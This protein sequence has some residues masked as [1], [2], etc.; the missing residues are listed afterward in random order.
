M[1]KL[2]KNKNIM[3]S[4]LNILFQIDFLESL[5]LFLLC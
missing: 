5:F 4:E 3:H 1:E 2:S